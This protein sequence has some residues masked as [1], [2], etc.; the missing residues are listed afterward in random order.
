L[1]ARTLRTVAGPRGTL[2][3]TW[4]PRVD[5][6]RAATRAAARGD[7]VEGRRMTL[8][9][10]PLALWRKRLNAGTLGEVASRSSTWKMD[11]LYSAACLEAQAID[12]RRAGLHGV[13][14]DWERQAADVLRTGGRRAA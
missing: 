2:G 6:A 9:P 10:S 4:L 5:V 12:A 1:V 8:T 3:A 13:A 11:A 14:E 7:A